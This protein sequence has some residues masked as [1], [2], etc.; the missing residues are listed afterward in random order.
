M[1]SFVWPTGA[2]MLAGT[3]GSETFTAGH[4][5]ELMRRGIK[6]QIVTVGHGHNDGRDDFP[7]IPFLALD[8]KSEIAALQG[9]VIFINK[10]YEVTTKNKSAVLLHCVT[11]GMDER[12]EYI[13]SV[14]G[15]TIIVTS[16]YSGQEWALYLNVPYSRIHI[17]LPFA[18]PV[19]GGIK[20][21]ASGKKVRIVFGGRLHPDKGI[22]TLL[23]AMHTLYKDK[24]QTVSIVTAG[25]HVESGEIIN[26]ML[27]DYSYARLI[28][29]Q[30]SAQSMARI[31][32][33]SDILLM[34]SVYAEPFGMLSIEAQQAG[35]RVVA[36]NI[37][38]LPETNSGL[39][40][41]VEPHSPSALIK[42]VH[43]AKALG[44]ATRKERETAKKN[45]TLTSSVDSLLLALNL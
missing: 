12:Q 24:T 20:R 1:L 45:F 30:K 37:G 2:P 41:L 32:T 7:E 28:P 40:T 23:E 39:L 17:V 21:T 15:R 43:I 36:S 29:P 31:L 8:D 4:A 13:N 6:M 10:P 42:G 38:G 33:S 35:C 5:R 14:V 22:Y 9:T 34:P 27:R 3:G 25:Q 16:V 11:P 44:A 18:D 19:F 26:K